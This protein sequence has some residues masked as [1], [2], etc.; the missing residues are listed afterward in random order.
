[1]SSYELLELLEWM[2]DRGAFKTAAR[3]EEYSEEEITWRH[4]ANELARL[5]ATMHAV[6]GGQQ[7]DPPLLLSRAEQREEADDAEAAAE[8][9]E[10]FFAFADRS[11]Q[12]AIE[13]AEQ[14][15]DDLIEVGG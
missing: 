6:H 12:Y 3:G 15:E 10:E 2:P 4:I 13:A 1:M 11:T 9:R 5:R 8:R 14:D 7:Y